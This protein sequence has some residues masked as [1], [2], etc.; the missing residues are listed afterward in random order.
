MSKYEGLAKD[1][2]RNVG[3]KENI[4]SL[5]HC[6]TRLR[7]QLKDESKANDDAIKS[8]NGVVTLMKSAGQYQVVIGNHVPDVYAEVCK[9]AGIQ[10][11]VEAPKKNMKLS[12]KALD[13]ISGIFA[14]GLAVLC[15]SG[16]IKGF[17]ALFVFLGWVVD[18]G[19][20][21]QLFNAIGD[22]LFYFFPIIIGYTSSLKFGLKP[23]LGLT[24]G[25]ALVYPAIQGVDLEIFGFVVNASYSSTV[26]PII[27]I[28]AFA[29][30]LERF[31]DRI[32]PDVVKTFITPMLV[33]VIA[34]PLGFMVIGPIANSV[35]SMIANGIS[36]GYAVSPVL[37]GLLL[38]GIW[39]IL[40]IFG[41]H[42]GVVMLAIVGLMAGNT[43]PLLALI[44]GVSFAQTAVVFAIWLKTKDAKLKAIA[45]PAWISGIFGVT[46][47]AIYGVTLPRIKFFIISCIGGA[48]SGA[49]FGLT[50]LVMQ[51]MAGMGVFAIPGF[52]H[53]DAALT[54]GIMMNVAIGTFIAV[55]FSFIATFV[56]FK[57]D[58][59][60]ETKKVVNKKSIP[61]PMEGT[62]ITLTSIQDAAFASEA[63]GKGIA[64]EPTTGAV[65]SPVKG[66]VETL[67][68]TKH[69]IGLLSEE[70]VEVLIHIGLDTVQLQGKYFEAHVK[71]GD[72]VE[73]GTPLVSFDLEKI[74]AEGY[75]LVTPIVITN[76]SSYLDIVETNEEQVSHRDELLTVLV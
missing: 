7:F 41:V 2:I 58:K 8:M 54:P 42:M 34:I 23:L 66:R 13:L 28:T 29:A 70:G 46:E 26:L 31:F 30:Q 39:Q 45:L 49:F 68:P 22:A 19:G 5:V 40:V 65:T 51:R 3:G 71:Q 24:L 69:A 11:T 20:T 17:L 25:A 43:D 62:V 61:S 75:S 56:M 15:A 18:G 9:L 72:L 33:M 63:L 27:L 60:V 32:V 4:V 1:I 10:G 55:A 73:V 21:Y 35:S 76:T 47:P 37:V 52:I 6:V 59:V 44:F 16:M 57:D 36:A 50:G 14:P 48:L 64:I 74:K 67:F 53:A 12:A 38:G